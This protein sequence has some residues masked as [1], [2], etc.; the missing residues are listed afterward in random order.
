MKDADSTKCCRCENKSFIGCS[1]CIKGSNFKPTCSYE[2]WKRR[3][4]NESR[5]KRN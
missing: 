1:G 4:K 3:R 5:A 2:E